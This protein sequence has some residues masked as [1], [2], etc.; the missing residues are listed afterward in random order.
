M[1]KKQ[2]EGPA[3]KHAAHQAFLKCGL[4]KL[5][6]LIE[7]VSFFWA[8]PLPGFR[9]TQS[10]AAVSG[11]ENHIS[12]KTFQSILWLLEFLFCLSNYLFLSVLERLIIYSLT[13]LIKT[14]Q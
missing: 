8:A 11:V 7:R 4:T 12:L 9:H 13:I 14:F 2:E 6:D 3:Y 1:S 10:Q 5:S